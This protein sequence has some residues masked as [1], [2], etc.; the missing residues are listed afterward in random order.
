MNEDNYECTKATEPDFLEE[1]WEEEEEALN[2]YSSN[3]W[4][5]SYIIPAAIGLEIKV[6]S[7]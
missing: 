6:M 7:V 5:F 3:S 1:S 2:G 4:R